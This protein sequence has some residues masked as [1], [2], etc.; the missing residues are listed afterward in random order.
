MLGAAKLRVKLVLGLLSCLLIIQQSSQDSVYIVDKKANKDRQVMD[1]PTRESSLTSREF[2]LRYR[3]GKSAFAKLSH[4]IR[5]L[6]ARKASWA[7]RPTI[8]VDVA[9]SATLRWL[10]GG[11]YLDVADMHGIHQSTFY[12]LIW[13]VI[14]AI[15]IVEKFE[16]PY[17]DV[18]KLTAIERGFYARNGGTLKGCVGA[19]DGIAV[20]ICKPRLSDDECPMS[21]YCRKSCF[22]LNVQVSP[23]R[24]LPTFVPRVRR[25]N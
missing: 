9:L 18:E 12:V 20:T 24:Y 2:K 21:Y 6:V 11:S 8:P 19:I 23:P 14:D 16:F 13:R 5:P 7:G 22:A 4:K 1:W 10:A 15:N 25:L 17:H 3:L